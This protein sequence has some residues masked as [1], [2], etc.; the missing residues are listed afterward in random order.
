[1]TLFE[2]SYVE[3]MEYYG[4]GWNHLSGTQQFN[5]IA[6]KIMQQLYDGSEGARNDAEFK[7]DFV[8]AYAELLN[9]NLD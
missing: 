4:N 9:A 2:Q 7:S 5:A 3:M 6:A 8:N 1:M